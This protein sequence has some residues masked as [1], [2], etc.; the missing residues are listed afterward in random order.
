MK[1]LIIITLILFL[2]IFIFYILMNKKIKKSAKAILSACSAI[3]ISLLIYIWFNPVWEYPEASGMYGVG[4]A[5]VT[6]TDEKRIESYRDDGSCRWL[7]IEF[8]YPEDYD[9]DEHA[10]PLVLFSH[11]S[12]GIKESNETLYREFASHGYVV[13][14]IDHTYQCLNTA[15]PDGSNVK[16]DQT[17]MKQILSS[18]DSSPEKRYELYEY[19]KEWMGVRTADINFILDTIIHNLSIESTSENGVYRLIDA[20]NIGLIGHSLGG[21]AVLGVARTRDDI[22]G[23]ISLEAPFMCDVAGVDGKGNFI[24]NYDPYTVPVLNVYTDSSW[25]IL[26]SSPQYAANKNMLDDDSASTYDIHVPGAGHMTLTDLAFD[27]PPLCLLF[28]QKLFFDVDECTS[29]LNH[30]YL[31][32]FNCCLKDG[33]DYTPALFTEP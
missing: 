22:S 23:V 25:D 16:I 27:K 29:A 19:F 31:E 6:Y 11:G 18:G 26:P 1:N 9:G 5:S 20:S 24:W 28:G 33:G 21:S 17:Y 7:N 15:A 32:F 8:W 14:A 4:T 3:L 30:T 13:C 12:L 2:F 10:C